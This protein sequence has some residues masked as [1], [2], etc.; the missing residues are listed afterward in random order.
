MQEQVIE[1]IEM[2]RIFDGD[3]VRKRHDEQSIV[4]LSKSISVCGLQEPIHVLAAADGTY[5]VISGGRRL[6][7]AR[8]AGMRTMAAIIHRE[9]SRADVLLLQITENL[10]REDLTPSEKAN[11][12]D[13]LMKETGGTASQCA[14]K[15]GLTNG[16]VSKLLSILSLP[17]ELQRR[18]DAGELSASAAYHLTK[19]DDPE[20]R[21]QLAGKVARG[22]LTRDELSSAIKAKKQRRRGPKKPRPRKVTAKFEN[23][24]K[25]SVSAPNLDLNSFVQIV[26]MLLAHAQRARNDG[27]TLDAL[28]KRF[29]GQRAA[30]T[31]SIEAA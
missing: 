18:I 10:Q 11:A 16:T 24:A 23:S 5:T 21:N 27:M 17:E 6:R 7:A 15:L 30:A 9:L 14:S 1:Q 19:V 28:I 29:S 8:H 22:E 26:E 2:D 3:N 25:V 20:M 13:T 31:A 12:I 4:G